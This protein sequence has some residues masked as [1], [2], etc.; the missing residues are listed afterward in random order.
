[1][2][3]I[4]NKVPYLGD[5]NDNQY[6]KIYEYLLVLDSKGYSFTCKKDLKSFLYE[7]IKDKTYKNKNEIDEQHVTCIVTNRSVIN[8]A[9]K[10]HVYDLF[11]ISPFWDN[12]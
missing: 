12:Y 4:T 1:M 2:I 7:R 10:V 3:K 11:N 6:K 8:D 5:N 9:V